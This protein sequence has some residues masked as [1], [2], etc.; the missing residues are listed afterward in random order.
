MKP[1]SSKTQRSAATR[2]APKLIQSQVPDEEEEED[3][4]PND[5]DVE[6]INDESAEGESD[7]EGEHE[8][9]PD[10]QGFPEYD[11]ENVEEIMKILPNTFE[12]VTEKEIS[13]ARE[14]IAL[15]ENMLDGNSPTGK[16][17]NARVMALTQKMNKKPNHKSKKEW[18]CQSA[19]EYVIENRKQKRVRKSTSVDSSQSQVVIVD[20]EPSPSVTPA[21]PVPTTSSSGLKLKRKGAP[22]QF[23]SKKGKF[24]IDN[25]SDDFLSGKKDVFGFEIVGGEKMKNMAREPVEKLESR[26]YA[27]GDATHICIVSKKFGGE[28]G[29]S[30]THKY[31]KFTRRYQTDRKTAIYTFNMH[32]DCLSEFEKRLKQLKEEL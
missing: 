31:L 19:L 26:N 13:V 20:P 25:P 4:D 32:M 5:D 3:E 12:N 16:I 11:D 17:N 30:T 27:S 28:G 29:S 9:L 6:F 10:A 18:M 22:E 1:A 2:A 23:N 21:P 24:V 8:M 14:I 15:Y 7:S